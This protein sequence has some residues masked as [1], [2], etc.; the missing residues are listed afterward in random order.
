MYYMFYTNGKVVMDASWRRPSAKD[1][2]HICYVN[3][4][5]ALIGDD[6]YWL[7]FVNNTLCSEDDDVVPAIYKAKLLLLRE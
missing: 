7:R 2:V 3:P 6:E 5:H 1:D 4:N